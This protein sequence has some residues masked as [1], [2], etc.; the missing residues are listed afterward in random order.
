MV[1]V[2]SASSSFAA[3]SLTRLGTAAY[4]VQAMFRSPVKRGDTRHPF[5]SNVSGVEQATIFL[6]NLLRFLSFRSSVRVRFAS[7]AF[8]FLASS[9]QLSRLTPELEEIALHLHFLLLVKLLY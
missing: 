3:V 9:G 2:S 5:S 1:A 4:G 8:P 7:K 6:L